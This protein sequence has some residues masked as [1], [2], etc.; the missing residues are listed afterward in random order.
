MNKR[1]KGVLAAVTA[2]A[3]TSLSTSE[4]VTNSG[5]AEVR[6]N[7]SAAENS[8]AAENEL[9]KFIGS[10]VRDGYCYK[11]TG[12]SE[13]DE[14]ELISPSLFKA[15]WDSTDKKYTRVPVFERGIEF[16]SGKD[17][18]WIMESSIE[19]EI[20]YS[21]EG[22]CFIGTHA[23]FVGEETEE[24]YSTT[25]MY[26]IDAKVN[27][28]VPE[29]AFYVNDARDKGN[30]YDIYHIEQTMIGTGKGVKNDI[31]YVINRNA[32]S[33][34]KNGRV[35]AYHELAPFL[36]RIWSITGLES[37]SLCAGIN[38]GVSKGSAEMIRNDITVPEKPRFSN[39]FEHMKNRIYLNNDDHWDNAAQTWA[40]NKKYTAFGYDI[41][42]KGYVGDPIKCT[43]EY[44]KDESE[45][46]S[47]PQ[48]RR[49][50]FNVWKSYS[51]YSIID[52]QGALAFDD[53]DDLSV[54][55][56]I[57]IGS[58]EKKTSDSKWYIG[59]E[60]QC[61]RDTTASQAMLSVGLLENDP[62]SYIIIYDKSENYNFFKDYDDN[63]FYAPVEIGTINSNGVE[64]DVLY[65]KAK[66]RSAYSGVTVIRKDELEPVAA[67]NIPSGCT[68]YEN[69][70]SI[71]DILSKLKE[72][73]FDPG[74]ISEAEFTFTAYD[75]SGTAYLNH[76]DIKRTIPEW[77]TF[78]DEDIQLMKDYIIGRGMDSPDC[79]DYLY[80][81]YQQMSLHDYLIR[82]N[83]DYD[84]N[85]DGVWDIYDLCEMRKRIGSTNTTTYVKPEKILKYGSSL[86]VQ[87]DDLKLYIGPDESYEMITSI[88]KF[89]II[90]ELGMQNNNDEWFFTEYNGNFGWAKTFQA[91]HMTL[92][93]I[94]DS[95]N[96]KP[97]IYLYPEQET[98]V[99]VELELTESEL[100]TTY[101]KYTNGWDVTAYPDGTLLNKADGTHHKYLFWDSSNCRTRYD[102]SKGFCVA[103]SDT[104]RFLKEK[105]TYMGLTEDEMNEFIVYWLP[106]M[107]HNKY[108]LISFQGEV[109][110]DSAKLDITPKPDSI[111]RVFM[112]YVPLKTATDIEPQQLETFE[113][114]GFTVVE[115]GGSIINS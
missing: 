87:A 79:G 47:Y 17:Y 55:Y 24:H 11:C 73:G 39:E 82:M 68:R 77:K 16:E 29:D 78:S 101:P 100:Y 110:T 83:K 74:G 90:R 109:Y 45:D 84:L 89:S 88:P 52:H 70:Y 27:W 31:Y 112:A 54:E 63:Y 107:E 12:C 25:D 50:S 105:L 9:I 1:I 5:I 108:N 43:W 42:M 41:E 114:K 57:D 61:M 111:L 22:S 18:N 94:Y 51:S 65:N 4:M 62:V 8:N 85:G 13:D 98:D 69:S 2:M 96:F 104:E 6:N 10:G 19:Y 115:W 49:A 32:D 33:N 48:F 37:V 36:S 71:T 23:S 20:E 113:R 58:I 97:V 60:I 46:Y 21:A 102:F 67:D 92:T 14:M 95:M 28:E 44:Y 40:D 3:I 76:A 53:V 26:I 72:N 81:D 30:S 93:G 86:I 106:L 59:A 56:S 103:G 75:T 64:Y 15:K 66:N 7:V 99:H 80:H 91:D 34:G 38:G 35:S